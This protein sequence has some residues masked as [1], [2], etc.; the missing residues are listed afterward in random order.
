MAH[1]LALAYFTIAPP[2]AL[3][4]CWIDHPLAVWAFAL[5]VGPA[6]VAMTALGTGGSRPLGRLGAAVVGGTRQRRRGGA[7]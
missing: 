2:L 5:L 1:R 7:L 6:P 4:S 3:A